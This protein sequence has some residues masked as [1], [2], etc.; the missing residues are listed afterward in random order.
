MQNMQ[1]KAQNT[2]S[3]MDAVGNDIEYLQSR[4]RESEDALSDNF[5][6][7]KNIIDLN[8]AEVEALRSYNPVYKEMI[9]DRDSSTILLQAGGMRRRTLRRGVKKN[10]RRERRGSIRSRWQCRRMSSSRSGKLK[11][12]TQ[13]CRSRNR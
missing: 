13:R 1:K 10:T 8:R 12:N 2:K 4:I 9:F 5:Q 11:K 6:S 7:V 3:T